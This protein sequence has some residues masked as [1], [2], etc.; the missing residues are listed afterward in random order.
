MST[1]PEEELQGANACLTRGA[2]VNGLVTTNATSYSAGPPLLDRKSQS[3]NYQVAA[4][5]FTRTGEVFSGAY[6]LA[7]RSEVARCIYG[8]TNAPVKATV[9]VFDSNGEAKVATV[10]VAER[11][12]WLTLTALNFEYSK[13]TISVKLK[14]KKKK[15]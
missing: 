11:R 6:T 8:F 13:P 12:G 9:Q 3:L 14:G 1:V 10:S 7:L 2:Q 4:P 5:H 15:R